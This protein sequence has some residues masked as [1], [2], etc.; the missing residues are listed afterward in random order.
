MAGGNQG[1]NG[2][3]VAVAEA[4]GLTYVSDLE[5]PGFSRRKQGKGFSYRT[6]DGSVVDQA[7]RERIESLAIPPAWTDVW[8]AVDPQA[9][10]QVTGR[11]DRD[12]KQYLYHERWRMVRD[13]MKFERLSDFALRLPAVREDLD[14]YLRDRGLSRQRVLA[15]VTRLMD[16]TFIRVG[17][18]EYAADNETY[19]AT[20]ILPEH[21]VDDGRK[22]T[23]EFPGKGGIEWSVPVVD[24]KVRKV[25]RECLDTTRG[26]LFCSEVEG[27]QRDVTSTDVND[28]LREVAGEG[29]S[30]K[31]FRTW[32][33]TASVT[34]SLGPVKPTD[35]PNELDAQELAA[36]D[37]AAE[38]LGNTRAVARSCY[39]APQVPTSWRTG[40]LAEHW[41][42]SRKAT[43]LS[44]SER[45]TSRV[46]GVD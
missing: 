6:P 17:N 24:P 12:R 29:F 27:Q 31:D 30:A 25:I 38:V 15:A 23:L 18:E 16:T 21:V 11:D 26:D 1:L 45:A 19:G 37:A 34:G 13:A 14:G 42:G 46:L 43:H 5:D 10:I 22:L 39:I 33:G 40:E 41:K 35:D 36:I 7:T 20:T 3:S 4:S 28:F 44:R 2:D 32:G 8:I 9:H